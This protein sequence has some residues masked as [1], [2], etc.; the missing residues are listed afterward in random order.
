[1]LGKGHYEIKTAKMA[2]QKEKKSPLW[3]C[4]IFNERYLLFKWKKKKT[5]KNNNFP[6]ASGQKVRIK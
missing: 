3:V 4:T 1:M 2:R 6:F 5:T